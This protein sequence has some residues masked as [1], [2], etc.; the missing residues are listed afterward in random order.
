MEVLVERPEPDTSVSVAEASLYDRFHVLDDELRHEDYL[1]GKGVQ[2]PLPLELGGSL[3][4]SVKAPQAEHVNVLEGH[5]FL[6]VARSSCCATPRCRRVQK[7]RS[8]SSL[9]FV[10]RR[11]SALA[12]S[13]DSPSRGQR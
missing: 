8:S 9:D 12:P 7:Q 6:W 13:V 11:G 5:A 10:L 2:R 4:L 3:V 1:D